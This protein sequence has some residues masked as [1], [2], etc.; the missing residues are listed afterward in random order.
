MKERM[1]KLTERNSKLEKDVE[2][3]RIESE[4]RLKEAQEEKDKLM[5]EVSRLQSQEEIEVWVDLCSIWLESL[6]WKAAEPGR[7]RGMSW[8]MFNM[9]RIAALK[10]CRARKRSRYEL[11]YVQYDSN[12]CIERLQS[13]EEIEVWVDLC[14]IWLE[15]LHWKA[16]EPG[17]DRGM[18]W[19]MFN[20]TRIAALKGCRARKRSRYELTYVQYD[21][22]RC[23]ERLQS[24]EE[25]KVWVDLCSI[26]LESLHWKA[27]EPGR[28]RGMSWLMFNMTR[29]AALKGCRARKR[30]RYELTYVQYDSNRCI[31][32]LQSQEEIEV[33]VDLCSIWL[34]SLHWKAAEP[35]RDWGMSWLMFNMTRIAALKGC[36]ARKRLRYELTYVQYDSNRCIERLQSQEEIEVWIDLRSIWLES[37]HWKAAEQGRDWG[38]SW[39]VFNMTWKAEEPARDWGMNWL[40]FNMTRKAEEPGRD[41]GMNWLIFNMT[42]RLKSQEEIEVWID[43]YSIWLKGWRVRKRSRYE[44]TCIQYDSKAEE[45]GTVFERSFFHHKPKGQITDKI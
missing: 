1:Q 9:T 40:I 12:R 3:I 42:Q 43:L 18:S 23:I 32:R 28:D 29:I 45:P 24:Q 37:L 15:S 41:W 8:L 36:R 35:G 7:D 20:M 6:H 17:R 30:S 33:W 44:L 27:A 38:M 11:T 39:L 13:Q 5:K 2:K 26:W 10:G 14:S 4:C 34:E 19:L 16:A 21:S 31:E 25:I 22:N